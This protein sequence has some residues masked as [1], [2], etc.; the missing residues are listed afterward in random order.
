[1]TIKDQQH[2]SFCSHMFHEV[3]APSR[4]IFS[5]CWTVD[6]FV[7]LIFVWVET[8]FEKKFIIIDCFLILSKKIRNLSLGIPTI[9]SGSRLKASWTVIR[10]LEDP[11]C[12]W[13]IASGIGKVPSARDVMPLKKKNYT[14]SIQILEVMIKKSPRY[15]KWRSIAWR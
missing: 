7:H 2:R 3:S 6:C 1:M 8:F 11:G 9:K 13:M 10:G 12:E 4:K 15:M 5:I 14:K